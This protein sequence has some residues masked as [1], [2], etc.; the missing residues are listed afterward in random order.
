MDL[1]R[2]FLGATAN[3]F[4]LVGAAGK[5]AV[6]T[7]P[8]G[9]GGPP[10][11]VDG[12]QKE[13][14]AT[15]PKP[16]A[17]ILDLLERIL[18]NGDPATTKGK[19]E[20]LELTEF[21]F[22]VADLKAKV[23]TPDFSDLLGA[24]GIAVPPS[25]DVASPADFGKAVANAVVDMAI[26]A[27]VRSMFAR[28][29]RALGEFEEASSPVGPRTTS[30]NTAASLANSYSE[31]KTIQ[32]RVVPLGEVPLPEGIVPEPIGPPVFVGVKPR[33]ET[34]L[35]L[36]LHSGGGA[37]IRTDPVGPPVWVGPRLTGRDEV[38]KIEPRPLGAPRRI[39]QLYL[40]ATAQP[41]RTGE[42]ERAVVD[43]LR[44]TGIDVTSLE[45]PETVAFAPE[46]V[47]ILSKGATTDVSNR[48]APQ[49]LVAVPL[50]EP[51]RK[52]Q[53]TDLTTTSRIETKEQAGAPVTIAANSAIPLIGAKENPKGADEPQTV[54]PTD[55]PEAKAEAEEA[56]G[57]KQP[58]ETDVERKTSALAEPES[59]PTTLRPTEPTTIEKRSDP[60][61]A[62]THRLDAHKAAEARTKV[63][64]QIQE[65]TA[66]QRTGS[67]TIR[68]SPEELGSI[69]VSLKSLGEGVEA[70]VTASNE[71]VRQSLHS[72]RA[73]LVQTAESKGLTITSLTVGSEQH[74]ELNHQGHNKNHAQDMRQEYAR[75]INLYGSQ[76]EKPQ[77]LQAYRALSLTGV[78]T[79]A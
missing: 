79:F 48:I 26:P 19:G 16:Q 14:A 49:V 25:F 15:E 2:L 43:A 68:L 38:S 74:T 11:Y 8:P 44:V 1:I 10:L 32:I 21:A 6:D 78:D 24:L 63:I 33:P 35:R 46:R 29:V 53:P 57:K 50:T 27:P 42:I 70:T 72:H 13:V 71:S 9:P 7:G 22:R 3:P 41:S 65:I 54:V 73:D 37:V 4:A 75:S 23:E 40:R 30:A 62:R 12:L 64:E 55:K 67:V 39:P 5:P 69:T 28:V 58:K 60:T 18:P 47:S 36:S 52:G 31:P 51:L 61:V 56:Q 17:Q 66:T 34:K 59:E 76:N 77:Q 45:Q 20:G